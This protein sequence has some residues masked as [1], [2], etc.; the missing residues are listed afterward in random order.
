[1]LNGA[2]PPLRFPLG[3]IPHS[4]RIL[5]ISNRCRSV[6]CNRYN[7]LVLYVI[8]DKPFQWKV[9]CTPKPAS[10]DLRSHS[11][12]PPCHVFKDSRNSLPLSIKGAHVVV[13]YLLRITQQVPRRR[14]NKYGTSHVQ[15]MSFC[16]FLY[17]DSFLWHTYACYF[18]HYIRLEVL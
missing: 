4:G 13:S 15:I 9:E 11:E 3:S 18:P 14:C 17:L 1:M 8:I 12:I 2:T 6:L 5:I 10:I 7:C 16:P